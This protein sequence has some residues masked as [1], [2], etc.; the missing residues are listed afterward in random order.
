MFGKIVG[1]FSE[2][3]RRRNIY[4]TLYYDLIDKIRAERS[5]VADLDRQLHCANRKYDALVNSLHAVTLEGYTISKIQREKGGETLL[6]FTKRDSTISGISFDIAVRLY[7]YQDAVLEERFRA[8]LTCDP[9]K[10]R[11]TIIDNYVIGE[12]GQGYGS[13]GMEEIIHIARE[14]R[15][16]IISGSLHPVDIGCNADNENRDRVLRFYKK[17]GFT[18]RLAEDGNSGHIRLYL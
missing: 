12:R 5:V 11:M 9:G 2:W 8:E 14:Q 18:V 7:A 15:L 17:H 6:F 4:Y 1:D 16:K 3:I 13:K 10:E